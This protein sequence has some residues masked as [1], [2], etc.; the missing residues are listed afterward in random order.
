MPA[1]AAVKLV[2]LESVKQSSGFTVGDS[3][4]RLFIFT[5]RADFPRIGVAMGDSPQYCAVSCFEKRYP[6][7]TIFAVLKSKYWGHITFGLA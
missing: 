1:K 4:N 2:S 3:M 6:Q 5:L 7:Q